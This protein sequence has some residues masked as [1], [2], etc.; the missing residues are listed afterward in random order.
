MRIQAL[1]LFCKFWKGNVD[2]HECIWGGILMKGFWEGEI[3]PSLK[4]VLWILFQNL[5]WFYYVIFCMVHLLLYMLLL[6]ALQLIA[7]G[8]L[9]S[10]FTIISVIRKCQILITFLLLCSI[11]SITNN[12]YLNSYF[13][14]F[15]CVSQD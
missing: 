4:F 13:P 3:V 10:Y 1:N 2:L 5:S 6:W 11:A 12:T 8:Q 9:F 15:C 14:H 7:L